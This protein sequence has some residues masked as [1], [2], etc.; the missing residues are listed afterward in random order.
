MKHC[1]T[2]THTHCI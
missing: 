2:N 1:W